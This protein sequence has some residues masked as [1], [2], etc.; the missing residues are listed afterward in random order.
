[1]QGLPALPVKV[2]VKNSTATI[3][4]KKDAQLLSSDTLG[5]Y[6]TAGADASGAARGSLFSIGYAHAIA[7]RSVDIQTGVVME[8]GAAAVVSRRAR[9][10]RLDE[11]VDRPDDREHAEP[12]R[13]AGRARPGA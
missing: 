9:A 2:L 11:R 6:A 8:A 5:V 10:Q 12:G 1:M 7:T 4:I 3:T 13:E